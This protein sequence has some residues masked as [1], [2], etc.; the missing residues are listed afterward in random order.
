MREDIR[1]RPL[2]YIEIIVRLIAES[3]ELA[4]SAPFVASIGALS[5]GIVNRI[6]YIVG[7]VV[8]VL[9]VLAFFGFR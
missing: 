6:I 8:V 1:G 4:Y 3:F 7:L 2:S 5:G 9:A